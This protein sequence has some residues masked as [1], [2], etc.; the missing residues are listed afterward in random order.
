MA[1]FTSSYRKEHIAFC[2]YNIC[3]QHPL[4]LPTTYFLEVGLQELGARGFVL[5]Q[6]LQ[7]I[8][9]SFSVLSLSVLSVLSV[10]LSI[11]LSVCLSLVL[12]LL[13]LAPPSVREWVS[14]CVCMC[15]CVCARV[16]V[17]K[18]R[19]HLT[20]RRRWTIGRTRRNYVNTR[21]WASEWVGC[22][23]WLRLWCVCICACVYVYE[24][25][26]MR[27]RYEWDHLNRC[28]S[29]SSIEFNSSWRMT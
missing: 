24:C 10:A 12:L 27:W 19:R 18:W 8:F 15:V 11:F 9:L 2:Y 29:L 26:C 6:H 7:C 20:P 21:K 23:V 28:G 16:Q 22:E 13:P 4:T 14:E 5:C 3:D 1:R 17:W 25:V